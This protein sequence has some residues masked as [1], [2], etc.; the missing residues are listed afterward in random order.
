MDLK[1][2]GFENKPV[3]SDC[4]TDEEIEKLYASKCLGIES[5]QA[6]INTLWL[7]STIHFGLRGG[8]EQRELCW[9]DVKLKQTPDR[10]EYLEYSVER[11]T[12]TRTGSDP[13]DTRKIKPRMYQLREIQFLFTIIITLF[14]SQIILAEHECSTNCGD[15]KSNKSNQMLVFEERR[16]R[17]YP[18]KN[19]SEQSREPTNLAHI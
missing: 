17:E 9:G 19:L 8:K 6:V 14:K 3:T 16:K 4:L 10:K 5:P 18:E 13:R 11:Q 1:A 7:N 12:K 2:K 15:C